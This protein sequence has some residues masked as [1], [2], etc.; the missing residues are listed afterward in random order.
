MVNGFIEMWKTANVIEKSFWIF[1]SPFVL[2]ASV[3]GWYWYL[4]N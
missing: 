3:M 2:F 4:F 1:A